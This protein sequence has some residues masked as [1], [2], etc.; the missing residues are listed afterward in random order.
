MA[1][2]WAL[3]AGGADLFARVGCRDDLA[4]SCLIEPFEA[5]VALEVFQVRADRTLLAELARLVLGD[6]PGMQGAVDAL[7]VDRPA[8]AF[9]EGLA[10][11]GKIRERLHR[12]H[13]LARELLAQGFE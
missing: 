7:R 3:G 10:E 11:I 6:P 4:H 5:V 2:P 12:L 13:V 9:G 1:K 8:L